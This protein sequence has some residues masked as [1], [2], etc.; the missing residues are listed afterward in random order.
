MSS[1]DRNRQRARI[2]QQTIADIAGN[3]SA[4]FSH[5]AYVIILAALN[6]STAD[7][8]EDAEAIA[9][10]YKNNYHNTAHHVAGAIRN[11]AKEVTQ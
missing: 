7:A 6:A 9:E 2:V 4:A 3:Q 10:S 1:N 11:R 5:H 8:Y